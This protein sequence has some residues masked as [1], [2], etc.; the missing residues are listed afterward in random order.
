MSEILYDWLN[1]ELKLTKKVS[2]IPEDF[3]NGY[4][5]AEILSRMELIPKLSIYKNTKKEKDIIH[6]FCYLTKTLL[7][8]NIVLTE[9]NRNDIIRKSKFAAQILLFKIR[10]VLDKKCITYETLKLK[11]SKEIHNIYNSYQYFNDN[12]RY[13]RQY[14]IKNKEK[15]H[16]VTNNRSLDR[17]LKLKEK[18]KHLR[19]SSKDLN[20]IQQGQEDLGVYDELHDEIHSLE[21]NRKQNLLSNENAHVKNWNVSMD[22]AR[23]MQRRIYEENIKPLI[24]YRDSTLNYFA[25]SCEMGKASIENF[26]KNMAALGL[27]VE[28]IPG[29]EKNKKQVST[30]ILMMRMKEQL[31]MKIKAKKEKEK[32]D[33]KQL[34]EELEMIKHSEESERILKE[35]EREEKE[36]EAK[37]KENNRYK[38]LYRYDEEENKKSNVTTE[39]NKESLTSVNISKVY[40]PMDFVNSSNKIH[41]QEIKVGNRVTLFKTLIP[42]Y[43]EIKKVEE[44]KKEEPKEEEEYYSRS[45]PFNKELFFK[46]IENEN[47]QFNLRQSQIREEKKKKHIPL[48]NPVMNDI[49]DIVDEVYKYQKENNVDLINVD[50]W[51]ELTELFKANKP[52]KPLKEELEESENDLDDENR[53]D[54]SRIQLGEFEDDE[55]FDYYNY[56]YKWNKDLILKEDM[57]ELKFYELY[58]GIYKKEE[59]QNVDIKEYEPTAEELENLKMPKDIVTNAQFGDIIENAIE[60]KCRNKETHCEEEKENNVVEEEEKIHHENEGVVSTEEKGTENE[61]KEEVREVEEIDPRGK[62]WYLPI[63][64]SIIGYPLSG[65]KTQAK[66]ISDEYPKLKIYNV[67]NILEEKIKEYEQLQ[68]PIESDPKFKTFKPKQIEQWNEEHEKKVQEFASTQAII[69]PYIDNKEQSVK[70]KVLFSLLV[71]QLNIDF[72]SNEKDNII[73][74]LKDKYTKKQDYIK[75]IEELSKEEQET[76]KSKAK[77]IQTIQKEIDKLLPDFYLGF[78][79]VDFPSN[80]TQCSLLEHYLTNYIPEF[81]RPKSEKDTILYSYSNL[82]DI[83]IKKKNDNKLIQSGIDL[84]INVSLSQEELNRRYNGI[85]YDPNTNTIYH[86]E[87]NPPNLGDKKLQERLVDYIPGLNIEEFN[88][89][90]NLYDNSIGKV[91]SFYSLM[92]DININHKTYQEITIKEKIKKEDLFTN[93]KEN[94]ISIVFDNFYKHCLFNQENYTQ[95][96]SITGINTNRNIEPIIEK[97][98]NAPEEEEETKA[99]NPIISTTVPISQSLSKININVNFKN[100]MEH[101]YDNINII[102]DNFTKQYIPSIKKFFWFTLSQQKHITK[103]LTYIQSKFMKYLKR[104]SYKKQLATVYISKYNDLVRNHPNIRNEPKVISEFESDINELSEKMWLLIQEKKNED[105]IEIENIKK[106][107]ILSVELNSLLSHIEQLFIIEAD[108]YITSIQIIKEYYMKTNNND[109]SI[110]LTLVDSKEILSTSEEA[111]TISFEER[112]KA[113]YMKSLRLII[114][115]DIFIKE[116]E[117]SFKPSINN[118][119]SNLPSKANLNSNVLSDSLVT[120]SRKKN[121]KKTIA[122]STVSNDVAFYEEE[123]RNQIRNEKNKFKYRLMMIKNYSLRLY[124][125]INNVFNQVHESMDEWIID[126]VKVQND[127]LN[128]FIFYLQRAL[129][130][131]KNHISLDDTEFDSFDIYK[132]LNVENL[133]NDIEEP[134]KNFVF[135]INEL[136]SLHNLLKQFTTFDSSLVSYDIVREILVKKYFTGS[137][138]SEGICDFIKHLNY[139]KY[140]KFLDYFIEDV[141]HVN[142]DDT[143]VY[144]KYVNINK[145]FT[146]LI[147]LGS[148]V[149]PNVDYQEMIQGVEFFKSSKV[150]RENFMKIDWWFDEDE[151]LK[152]EYNEK[153]KAYFEENKTTKTMIIKEALFDINKEDDD[154]VDLM[155][156]AKQFAKMRKENLIETSKVEEKK[157]EV[158]VKEEVDNKTVEISQIESKE[159]SQEK[160]KES[161]K[162]KRKE[163]AEDIYFYEVIF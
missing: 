17:F 35:K 12:D 130:N 160:S 111:I 117:A 155:K 154:G 46:S 57:N 85:K 83:A 70:D 9:K 159:L 89:K 79:L 141:D 90:K 133:L 156:L 20:M 145:M 118:N 104:E 44:T 55:L 137:I 80:E 75:K 152:K 58:E 134:N 26:N 1:T 139:T 32:R 100:M 108:K 94:C 162:T 50:K 95:M 93:I 69:Q 128:N 113:I 76:K 119:F 112:I 84:L 18:F 82:I 27:D 41:H 78:V 131:Y 34:R 60:F 142:K 67:N 4:L 149:I 5:F 56:I 21:N 68:Q 120:S 53:Y 74:E 157:E 102:W 59:N 62:Y 51:T 30:E 161:I 140:R 43:N 54:D 22:D 45:K 129:H 33:R 121:K 37:N 77:D 123:I 103:Y 96:N 24:E 136:V 71:N 66:L 87:D 153:E 8:M 86:I 158:P 42:M 14:N 29:S 25:Q 64:I 92:G 105:I 109:N 144:E 52:I 135:N 115:Q 81:D 116:Y 10:Q 73:N 47:I 2:N 107:S 16:S 99:V 127:K 48:L 97:E 49:L 124:K 101:N 72:P 31:Q 98:E 15:V 23:A 143:I 151:Y 114:K 132:I 11:N 163:I 148:K 38:M 36:K 147:L 65:K 125:K 110:S 39:E 122:S 13:L 6:N 61:E 40:N 19:L 150:I 7:D 28:P 126:S 106:Q 88:Q 3:Q 63:K 146:S 91:T 138:I